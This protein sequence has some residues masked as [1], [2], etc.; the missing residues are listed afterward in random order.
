[1]NSKAVVYGSADSEKFK[2]KELAKTF[3]LSEGKLL[4]CGKC[5]GFRGLIENEFCGKGS[6]NSCGNLDVIAQTKNSKEVI[7]L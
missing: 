6:Q 4:I 1:L 7:S 2:I 3:V 5:I